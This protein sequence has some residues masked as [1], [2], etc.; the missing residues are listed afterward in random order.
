MLIRKNLSVK[1]IARFANISVN[2]LSALIAKS[3]AIGVRRWRLE[4]FA[5]ARRLIW[6]NNPIKND[7]N[8]LTHS[9]NHFPMAK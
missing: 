2:M 5:A 4:V 1:S 7:N 8:L 9:H 6:L 3:D